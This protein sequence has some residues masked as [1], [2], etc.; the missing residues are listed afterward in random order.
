MGFLLNGQPLAVGRPFTDADGT[1]YPS[2]WLR[3]ASE[4]EKAAI[5]ITWEADPAPVD[6]RF[7]WDHDLPKRLEDEPAVDEDGDP[8]LDADGVQI[9]N[10][11]LKIEWIAQQKQIAGSL[12]AQSDW[13]VTRKAEN[14]TVIPADVLAYRAAVRTASG[15][16]EAE[17]NA[18]TTTEELAALLTN[19]AQVMNDDGEWV[20]NTEPF[21]TPFPEP[22]N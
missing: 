9:I 16:R 22:L 19:P 3:L 2:N 14:D 13:Y 20:A 17:I 7:Y 15:T 6:T 4:D 8:V 12:L 5:G 11:G 10:K 18:C 1:Q 21:I